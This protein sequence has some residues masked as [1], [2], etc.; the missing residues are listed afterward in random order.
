MTIWRTITLHKRLVAFVCFLIL[1]S[2]VLLLLPI[3]NAFAQNES[4]TI[5]KLS[6]STGKVGQNVTLQGTINTVNGTYNILFGTSTLFTNTSV[7]NAVNAFFTVPEVPAGNYNVT[8]NDSTSGNNAT[9]TFTVTI[10][11]SIKALIPSSPAQLQEG[12]SVTLN[13]NV[14]GG[15]V[16]TSYFANVTVLLP[17]SSSTGFSQTIALSS[18]SS[19]GTAQAQITFPDAFTGSS[20]NYTGTY[21]AYFNQS[22]FLAYDQFIVGLTNSSTY[23]RNQNVPIQA[24]GYQPG[25]TATLSITNTETNVTVH[26]ESLTANSNGVFNTNWVVPSNAS[27]DYYNITITPQTTNKTVRD[28]QLFSIPGYSIQMRTLNLAGQIVPSI[29]IGALDTATNTTYNATT[30]SDGLA[31]LNLET[32]NHVITAYR[33]DKQVGQLNQVITETATYNLTC[34]LTNINVTVKNA[35]GVLMHSVNL[36]LFCQYISSRNG[37][38]L[39]VTEQGKTDKFGNCTFNSVFTGVS[40]TLNASVYGKVFN[41]NNNTISNLP[42]QPIFEALIICPTKNL[43]LTI[44]GNTSTPIANARLALI[45]LTN[46][47]FQNATTNSAGTANLRVT[48]GLYQLRVYL[49]DV[50]LNQTLVEVFG[51]S[52]TTIQCSR[53]GIQVTVSVV[54]FFG[55]PISNANVTI[56]GSE[57]GR[58]S[59]VTSSDGKVTFNNLIGGNMQV[60]AY[61]SGVENNYQAVSMTIDG[62]TIVTVKMGQFISLG[63]LII[64][65]NAFV[66]VVL[67]LA[68]LL[69]FFAIEI[70]RRRKMVSTIKT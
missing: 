48:F 25:E 30:G 32:G 8:L 19:G 52:Q 51:D 57:N 34:Q 39:N 69:L 20:T 58:L 26:T 7:N 59:N 11:Y 49:G 68:S 24:T 27:I 28:T 33:L 47:I 23:H 65:T 40:Y 41:I 63:P 18:T 55:N 50:L 1:T 67:I 13:V 60:V 53:Y 29:D 35:D 31:D 4:T 38:V 12:N 21:T 56:Y 62:S 16:G 64:W 10:G 45:E 3:P 22:Q 44:L 6:T 66:A 9:V 54:D 70:I 36:T 42:A 14:T 2:S 5:T 43:T 61:P 15:Q 17:S 37:S 46:G